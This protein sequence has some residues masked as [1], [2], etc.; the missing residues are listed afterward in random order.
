M[1]IN[2]Q[3]V[4]IT[5][6]TVI[7][8][9][10]TLPPIIY[11]N[12]YISISYILYRGGVVTHFFNCHNCN[13]HNSPGPCLDNI[14]RSR[15]KNHFHSLRLIE[16]LHYLCKHERVIQPILLPSLDLRPWCCGFVL[17]DQQTHAPAC[18]F[19]GDVGG[20]QR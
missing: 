17:L 13:C 6:V 20:W 4:T 3:S 12:T 18:G 7:F 5:V 10:I 16:I 14:S 9:D 19:R 1:I 2:D 8:F 15:L 11:I